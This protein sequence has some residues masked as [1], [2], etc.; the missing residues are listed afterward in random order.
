[1][2]LSWIQVQLLVQMGAERLAEEQPEGSVVEGMEQGEGEDKD[3]DMMMVKVEERVP[4]EPPELLYI[5]TNM[6]YLNPAWLLSRL[7]EWLGFE[8]YLERV[9]LAA[10]IFASLT[11]GLLSIVYSFWFIVAWVL[12]T[13]LDEFVFDGWK[14]EDTIVDLISKIVPGVVIFLIEIIR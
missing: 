2:E 14:G 10:H 9:E 1:M 12:F 5:G 7:L 3:L 6:N 11:F 13:L 4:P 8:T